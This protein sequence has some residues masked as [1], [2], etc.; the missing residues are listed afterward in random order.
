MNSSQDEI[1][2]R[3]PLNLGSALS[4]F[5]KQSDLTQQ[6]LGDQAG[7]KQN[8]ISSVESGSPGTRLR[9]LFR[10]LA[11]LNLELIIRRRS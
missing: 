5:R 11:A 1:S 6:A 2:V 3:D 7:I 10:I 9:T 8:A 4:R